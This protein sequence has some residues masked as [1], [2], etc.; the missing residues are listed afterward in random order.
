MLY[1]LLNVNRDFVKKNIQTI[2]GHFFLVIYN[3]I[4]IFNMSQASSNPKSPHQSKHYSSSSTSH[5]N[6]KHHHRQNS[7]CSR[8]MASSNDSL[9]YLPR[10][11]A[12]IQLSRLLEKRNS[13]QAAMQQ[14]VDREAKQRYASAIKEARLKHIEKKIVGELS[15]IQVLEHQQQLDR[16]K[17]IRGKDALARTYMVEARFD[18]KQR[19]LN[20]M[21]I[22]DKLH[23]RT[24]EP[25][26][27]QMPNLHNSPNQSDDENI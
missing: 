13:S 15:R 24:S 4:K 7:S 23:P 25:Q 17:T 22:D 27:L 21:L 8:S 18:E 6:S 11:E 3:V 19:N 14:D 12:A 2:F 1:F 16:V 9:G 10:N 20:Q 26:P 5:Q